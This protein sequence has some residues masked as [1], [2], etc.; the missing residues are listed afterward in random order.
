MLFRYFPPQHRTGVLNIS[1]LRCV[2]KCPNVT[3]CLLSL[4]IETLVWLINELN[5]VQAFT[6]T[7]VM[8]LHVVF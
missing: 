1:E 7:L 5:C 3:I 4:C 2:L 8:F 6:E